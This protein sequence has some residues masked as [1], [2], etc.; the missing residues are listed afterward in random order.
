M[1]WVKPVKLERF[2]LAK[3]FARKQDFFDRS[4]F[5]NTQNHVFACI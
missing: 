1:F 4:V 3:M 2:M 5:R